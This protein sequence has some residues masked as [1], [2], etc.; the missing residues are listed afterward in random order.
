[1]VRTAGLTNYSDLHYTT[2]TVA[3]R[4][5]EHFQPDGRIL[6]PFR[7]TGVFLGALSGG[8]EWCEIDMGRDFLEWTEPVDWIVTNPPFSFLTAVMRQ[9]FE[10]ARHT[11][12]LVPMSKIYSSEPRMEL[13][14]DVAGIEEQLYLGSGRAIGFDI[15]FPFAAMKFTRGYRGP[16]KTSWA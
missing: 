6:E 1:M 7:G 16:T 2:P 4:I 13:V 5:V 8:T 15:G 11:V 12:L 3:K 9:C 10:V 14:R